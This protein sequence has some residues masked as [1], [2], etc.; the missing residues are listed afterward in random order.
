M[1]KTF[2][3]EWTYAEWSGRNSATYVAIDKP[4][5]GKF[6]QLFGSPLRGFNFANM[7]RFPVKVE[8]KDNV[9]YMTYFSDMPA[10]NNDGEVVYS[11][12]VPIIKITE[13]VGE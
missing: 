13:T 3:Y 9:T 5:N 8:V 7:N 1:T 2:T 6:C 12:V 11:K 4:I 10:T